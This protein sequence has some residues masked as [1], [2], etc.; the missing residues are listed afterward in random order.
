MN[1]SYNITSDTLWILKSNND[2]KFKHNIILKFCW[3][4]TRE[5]A[6]RHYWN[7]GMKY[8]RQFVKVLKKT[9]KH[10]S[11]KVCQINSKWQERLS[12]WKEYFQEIFRVQIETVSIISC[13]T[14][15]RTVEDKKIRKMIVRKSIKFK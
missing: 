6:F 5:L 1:N 9:H 10:V 4:K 14:I 11:P 3:K 2:L 12:W 7:H 13:Q 8:S 15:E